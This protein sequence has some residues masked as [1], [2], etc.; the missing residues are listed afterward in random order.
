MP[1]NITPFVGS[2]VIIFILLWILLIAVLIF[3]FVFWILMLVDAAKRNFKQEN[4][5]L[6]WVLI[7]VLTGIIGS[8]I[9]YYVVKKPD[10]K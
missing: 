2:M 5:K 1:M 10:K 8:T 9:Y 7:I 6:M 3:T 4:D